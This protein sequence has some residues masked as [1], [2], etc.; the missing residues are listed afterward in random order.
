MNSK[1]IMQKSIGFYFNFLSFTHPKKLKKDG[2]RLFFNP[3]ARKIK[4]PQLEFL[5]KR[6]FYVIN[7]D[8]Y[9]IQN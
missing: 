9:K 3:F 5:Q 4:T 7:L 1:K 8:G 2:F 6:M